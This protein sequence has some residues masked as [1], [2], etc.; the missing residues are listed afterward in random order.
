MKLKHLAALLA[1]SGIY[2]APIDPESSLNIPVADGNSWVTLYTEDNRGGLYQTFQMQHAC[3]NVPLEFNDRFRSVTLVKAHCGFYEDVDCKGRAFGTAAYP[4]IWREANLA[5]VH[6]GLGEG[7]G[8][9]NR[10]SSIWCIEDHF[11]RDYLKDG[12]VGK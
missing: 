4:E 10:I 9:N 8:W 6:N 2:A 11:L 7:E 1:V 5:N 12:E 3:Q